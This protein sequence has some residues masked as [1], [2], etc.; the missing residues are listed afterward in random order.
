MAKKIVPAQ[1]AAAAAAPPVRTFDEIKEDIYDNL[2][3]IRCVW[4]AL[5]RS[6]AVDGCEIA[7][8][9]RN[10]LNMSERRI[11]RLMDELERVNMKR[12]KKAVAH[13]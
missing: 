12:P 5:D 3:A 4:H 10:A 11:Y 8:P 1:P 13:G 6:P 2:N 7:A 9:A